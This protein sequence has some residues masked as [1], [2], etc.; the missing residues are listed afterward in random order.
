MKRILTFLFLGAS[1]ASLSSS[2]SSSVAGERASISL[3]S[4]NTIVPSSKKTTLRENISPFSKLKVSSII[5]VVYTQSSGGK[6]T[7][8]VTAPENLIQYV[9][10]NQKN[11]TLS[12]EWTFNG[13]VEGNCDI[14]VNI[15]A[16]CPESVSLSGVA[17]FSANSISDS[18]L[19]LEFEAGG[20]TNIKLGNVN[21]KSVEFGIS[22]AAGATVTSIK[23][24]TIDANCSGSSNLNLGSA[25]VTKADLDISGGASLKASSLT[26][27]DCEFSVAGGAKLSLP[28]LTTDNLQAGASGGSTISLD[29]SATNA[30]FSASGAAVIK[31]S[32]L[33][34][35]NGSVQA[36]GASSIKANI[37]NVTSKS[38]SLSSTITLK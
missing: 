30:D 22:G 28:S 5:D 32:N 8:T 26:A 21:L 16:P 31:A 14:T 3:N 6:P 37:A 36:S 9:S 18:S 23:A 34:V 38:A 13:S 19:N 27:S 11:S 33:K 15:S 17:S 24:N 7:A 29:G 35:T 4:R 12:I 1:L 10:L 2:C 20:A 25:K